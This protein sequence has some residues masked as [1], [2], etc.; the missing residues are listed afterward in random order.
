MTKQPVDATMK[1][2]SKIKIRK[3]VKGRGAQ[4]PRATEVGTYPTHRR[5]RLVNVRP[6]I[7]LQDTGTLEE[8]GDRAYS[9]VAVSDL[10]PGT[11]T[12]PTTDSPAGVDQ[13]STV[14]H[15]GQE[16]L[17]T[18]EMEDSDT[19]EIPTCSRR[20]PAAIF[21]QSKPEVHSTWLDR[22][23]EYI[24][25]CEEPLEKPFTGVSEALL[26]SLEDT[27]KTRGGPKGILAKVTRIAHDAYVQRVSSEF[28][29]E[30][31]DQESGA[32]RQDGGGE[33][34]SQGVLEC[35][36]RMMMVEARIRRSSKTKSQAGKNRKKMVQKICTLTRTPPGGLL[37]RRG[38]PGE[39][40]PA[41][42]KLRIEQY[43]NATYWQFAPYLEPV[44]CGLRSWIC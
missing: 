26:R 30:D 6:K 39:S 32:E 12:T 20:R 10:G 13:Y 33:E 42:A 5:V 21:P 9:A 16:L 29:S 28:E 23:R 38:V 24:E 40:I 36:C 44:H 7:L 17:S 3:G 14:V 25:D 11:T 19:N 35:V 1:S 18:M 4:P 2:S 31:T 8:P 27:E 37:D 41:M 34:V 15:E 22:C 43:S